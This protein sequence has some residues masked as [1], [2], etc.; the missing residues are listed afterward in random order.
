MKAVVDAIEFYLKYN[1]NKEKF[2]WP[3]LQTPDDDFDDKEG[4]SCDDNQVVNNS[5]IH[6]TPKLKTI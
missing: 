4:S 2:F 5:L 1:L 3:I 6:S